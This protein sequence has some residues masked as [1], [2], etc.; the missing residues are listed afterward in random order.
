VLC[1][2]APFWGDLTME[3]FGYAGAGL[4]GEFYMFWNITAATGQPTLVAFNSG[5][6][7]IV[8]YG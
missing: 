6:A 5:N 4:V 7:A 8:G 2:P 3:T 1:F